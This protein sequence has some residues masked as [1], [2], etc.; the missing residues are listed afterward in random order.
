M[1]IVNEQWI[2]KP[3]PAPSPAR[4]R[5][6]KLSGNFARTVRLSSRAFASLPRNRVRRA[7][8][9]MEFSTVVVRYSCR[10]A[11]NLETKEII[12]SEKK[13]KKTTTK[14]S[15]TKNNSRVFN[16]PRKFS[17]FTACPKYVFSCHTAPLSTRL[18]PPIEGENILLR[19]YTFT[20]FPHVKESRFVQAN[21]ENE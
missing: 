12:S 17:L 11:R 19:F 7:T 16:I 6:D 15:Q 1:S 13:R 14:R 10:N 2:I 3:D 5:V 21:I 8:A 18:K 9:E 20:H 4:A